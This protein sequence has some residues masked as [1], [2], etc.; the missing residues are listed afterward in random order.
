MLVSNEYLTFYTQNYQAYQIVNLL[1]KYIS[2]DCS[3]LDANAGMGGNSVQFCKFFSFVYCVD[4]SDFCI[5]YLEHNLKE[6]SNKF[7]INDNCLD[8]IKIIKCD[9]I[10]FDPPWGGSDYKYH[11]QID[12]YL[13]NVNIISIINNLF[14]N[15]NLNVIS[16]K[17]PK[18]F[19]IVKTY[20]NHKVYN[21]YKSDNK[22]IQFLLLIFFR[23]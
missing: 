19:R 11:K 6:F 15:K 17:A 8:I 12:L 9:T 14:Y 20:W 7:I 23:N 1:K 4:I 16:L 18:N 3:I 21:I 5:N 10:F 22:T 13:N 2:P